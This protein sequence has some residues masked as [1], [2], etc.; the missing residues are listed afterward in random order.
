MRWQKT[1]NIHVEK[2]Q[3]IIGNLVE[4]QRRR[5]ILPEILKQTRSICST[6]GEI[7]PAAYA[8]GEH[9]HVFFTRNCPNH[10]GVDTDLG[11]HAVF[12]PKS[13]TVEKLFLERYA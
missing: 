9:N 10:G 6:C 13:F 2:R 1:V 4:H 3:S 11:N 5:R 12:Y 8:I 7:I